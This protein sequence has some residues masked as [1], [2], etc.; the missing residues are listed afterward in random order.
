MG[1]LMQFALV[2]FTSVLFIVDPIEVIPTCL[3]ITQ[4]ETR[5]HRA[6]TARRACIAATIILVAFGLAGAQIFRLFASRSRRFASPVGSFCG[7]WRWT[8]CTASGA[9][10]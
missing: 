3:V 9:R 4:G 2:T 8:C 1:D 6:Q 5:E 7:S 10:R